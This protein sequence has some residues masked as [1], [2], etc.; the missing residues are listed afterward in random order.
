MHS[1]QKVA[2]ASSTRHVT[3]LLK[4]T[5]HTA[6]STLSQRSIVNIQSKATTIARPAS[7]HVFAASNIAGSRPMPATVAALTVSCL[8]VRLTHGTSAAMFKCNT[9]HMS[10]ASSSESETITPRHIR[11]MSDFSREEIEQIIRYVSVCPCSCMC[12]CMRVCVYL[13]MC[14]SVRLSVSLSPCSLVYVPVLLS[15][16]NGPNFPH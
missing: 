6:L 9:R 2:R 4:R 8:P 3:K 15:M 5:M 7:C 16:S 14:V 10:S 1:V 11:T 13:C 12:V